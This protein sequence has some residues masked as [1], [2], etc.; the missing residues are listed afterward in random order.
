MYWAVRLAACPKETRDAQTFPETSRFHDDTS[1]VTTLHNTTALPAH[2][3]H[4]A[5]LSWGQTAQNFA[6]LKQT[7]CGNFSRCGQKLSTNV[8]CQ[9]T[10]W[11][12][13]GC[14][15]PMSR[16]SREMLDTCSTLLL[17]CLNVLMSSWMT[18]SIHLR[19]GVFSLMICFFTMT[20]N[21]RSGVNSPVLRMHRETEAQRQTDGTVN[22]KA[23]KQNKQKQM[24]RQIMRYNHVAEVM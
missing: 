9:R 10:L 14:P 3:A 1:P 22:T 24:I 12:T 18:R 20:S 4:W 7:Y 6:F 16:L 17:H 5:G 15:C 8:L 11:H 21:A 23:K 2:R 13:H 19:Q